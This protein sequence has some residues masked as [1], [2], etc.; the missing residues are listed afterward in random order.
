MRSS[1]VII[2]ESQCW[3]AIAKL[4]LDGIDAYNCTSIYWLRSVMVQSTIAIYRLIYEALKYTILS[5][6]AT[7][8]IR[9]SGPRACDI[10][11][12][13]HCWLLTYFQTNI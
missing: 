12:F 6:R 8:T 5:D 9:H 10:A 2:P 7:P 4:Q 3:I 1:Y 11:T 13:T